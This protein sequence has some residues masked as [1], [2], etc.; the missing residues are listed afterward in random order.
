MDRLTRGIDKLPLERRIGNDGAPALAGTT[1][2]ISVQP[3][4]DRRA[5]EIMFEFASM[6]RTTR[7]IAVALP[8]FGRRWKRPIAS[9]QSIRKSAR[10]NHR[11]FQKT[12]TR[13]LI[14]LQR[15][16]ATRPVLR[17]RLLD[18]SNTATLHRAPELELSDADC[19]GG[20]TALLAFGAVGVFGYRSVTSHL[21]VDGPSVVMVDPTPVKSTPSTPA[22]DIESA[23]N[24]PWQDRIGPIVLR[25]VRTIPVLAAA[26]CRY[27]QSFRLQTLQVRRARTNQRK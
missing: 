21:A 22:A 10:P 14:R 25:R 16:M 18:I 24:K 1:H 23:K 8:L 20:R 11:R 26:L 2:A 17:L 13:D 12:K 27:R 15:M 19:D 4:A 6:W 5:D 7:L 9:A 3:A